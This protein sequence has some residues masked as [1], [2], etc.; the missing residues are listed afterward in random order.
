MSWWGGEGKL[1]GR[2]SWVLK[3]K[4]TPWANK[5]WPP[6]AKR[7]ESCSRCGFLD[8][9]SPYKNRKKN[10]TCIHRIMRKRNPTFPVCVLLVW[11]FQ[12]SDFWYWCTP[13]IGSTISTNRNPATHKQ[14][15][16]ARLGGAL[17]IMDHYNLSA[18]PFPQPIHTLRSG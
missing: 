5:W 14:I 8:F 4:S 16:G 2:K 10:T 18:A 11:T 1:Q 13:V 17:T 9:P 12:T 3:S 6:E 7:P 15:W